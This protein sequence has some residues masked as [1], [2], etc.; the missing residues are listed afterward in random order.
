MIKTRINAD[1][2]REEYGLRSLRRR[3]ATTRVRRP[4]RAASKGG[5]RGRREVR[6]SRPSH[7]QNLLVGRQVLP[8]LRLALSVQS[9][10][11]HKQYPSPYHLRPVPPPPRPLSHR[12]ETAEA[13]DV[14]AESSQR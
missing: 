13:F 12:Y 10:R 5:P 14:R 4:R 6:G 7:A 3:R 1:Q 9:G 2:I 8:T 11:R